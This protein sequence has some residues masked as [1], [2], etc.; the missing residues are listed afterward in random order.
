MIIFQEFIVKGNQ[1][2][3]WESMHTVVSLPESLR[4]QP[5]RQMGALVPTLPCGT[6]GCET[7]GS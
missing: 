2:G 7:W 6:S 1:Q 4:A 3:K 5:C